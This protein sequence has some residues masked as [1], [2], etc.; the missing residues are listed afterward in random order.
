MWKLYGQEEW[1]GWCDMQ[2]GLGNECSAVRFLAVVQIC[3][4]AGAISDGRMQ[5]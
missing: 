4:I 1:E 5:S 2:T 3:L